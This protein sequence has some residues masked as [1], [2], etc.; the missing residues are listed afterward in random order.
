LQVRHPVLTFGLLALGRFDVKPWLSLELVGD[1]SLLVTA[2]VAVGARLSGRIWTFAELIVG[3][4]TTD[5]EWAIN[6]DIDDS[7]SEDLAV[8]HSTVCRKH[9]KDCSCLRRGACAFAN[10]VCG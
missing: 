10:R 1:F 3:Q 6:D 7:S 5:Q 9:G 2:P 8:W 4:Q